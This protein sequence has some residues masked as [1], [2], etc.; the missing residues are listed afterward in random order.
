MLTSR[1]QTYTE[2]VETHLQGQG[3]VTINQS[4]QIEDLVNN[5]ANLPKKEQIVPEKQPAPGSK[6]NTSAS[7]NTTKTD[8]TDPD[9]TEVDTRKKV[10]ANSRSIT[11]YRVQ[12]FAGGNTRADRQKAQQTGNSIKRAFPNQPI[13]VH[14]YSPRWICRIGNF[15]TYE[16]ANEMLKEIRNMGYGS[17]SIVKGRITVQN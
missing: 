2:H 16:E 10:M 17:A 14:F 4:K 12:A 7:K 13:Y 15:R 1:A 3:S 9:I 6:T 8:K 11:G 5:K